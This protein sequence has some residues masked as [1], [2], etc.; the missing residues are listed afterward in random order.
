MQWSTREHRVDSVHGL[1]IVYPRVEGLRADATAKH[2][3]RPTLPLGQIL[4]H[5]EGLFSCPPPEKYK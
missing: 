5:E 1:S 4:L 2:H 3:L